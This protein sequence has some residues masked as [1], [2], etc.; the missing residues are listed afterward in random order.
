MITFFS[1][2]AVFLQ[3]LGQVFWVRGSILR[4]IENPDKIRYQIEAGRAFIMAAL[5]REVLLQA[6]PY[7]FRLRHPARFCLAC[8]RERKRIGKFDGDGGHGMRVIRVLAKAI[9]EF[10]GRFTPHPEWAF[11]QG[12]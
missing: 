8:K 2:L 5:I 1:T 12:V 10:K 9:P 3:C 11:F 7:H 6:C 4:A